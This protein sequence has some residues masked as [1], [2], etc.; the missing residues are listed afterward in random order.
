MRFTTTIPATDKRL[1]ILSSVIGQMSDGI[2]EKTRYME[3]Y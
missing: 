2:W 3:K 1:K